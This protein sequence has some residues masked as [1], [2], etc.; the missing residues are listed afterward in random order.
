MFDHCDEF[1]IYYNGI[2]YCHWYYIAWQSGSN[3][4]NII[5]I[6]IC[7]YC[8]SIDSICLMLHYKEIYYKK[9]CNKLDQCLKISLNDSFITKNNNNKMNWDWQMINWNNK[10]VIIM[11]MT[12]KVF[13]KRFFCKFILFVVVG[14]QL[15]FSRVLGFHL[16]VR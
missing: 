6:V 16:C 3:R 4:S 8:T 11:E 7:W 15:F 13:E 1:D 9:L 12:K 5:C 14:W 10:T 2:I